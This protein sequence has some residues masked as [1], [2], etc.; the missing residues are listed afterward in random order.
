MNDGDLVAAYWRTLEARDWRAFG[1]LLADDVTYELPQ[2]GERVRGRD[3]YVRF[4]VEYPG[5]WHVAVERLVAG[6][7]GDVATWTR[8]TLPDIGEQTALTFFLVRDGLV[9][10]IVEWWPEPYEPPAGREHLVERVTAS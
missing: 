8:F 7:D 5:E 3:R 6:G 9:R 1:A 2:T 10:S 4:N